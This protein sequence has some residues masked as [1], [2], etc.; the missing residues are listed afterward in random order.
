MDYGTSYIQADLSYDFLY[1]YIKQ[2]HGKASPCLSLFS[3]FMNLVI[4][5][6][7][8]T[9]HPAVLRVSSTKQLSFLET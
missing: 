3:V 7:I 8:L 4:A 2:K 9:P 5:L 1:G 6:K